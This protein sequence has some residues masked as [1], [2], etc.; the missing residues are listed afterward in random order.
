MARL[1]KGDE[2]AYLVTFASALSI[3]LITG[4]LVEH[5]WVDSAL[6]RNAFGWSFFFTSTWDAVQGQFG[7]LPFIYGTVVTSAM[8]LIISVP[9]GIGAAIFLAELAPR[10]VSNVLTFLIELLAA[11]PSVIFGLLGFSFYCQFSRTTSCRSF[12]SSPV[13]FRSFKAHST[14]LAISRHPA[15]CRS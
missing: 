15:F 8:A 10:K 4:L 13:F 12:K 14:A 6:S 2:I 9:I 7:A 11:V 3:V 5:L 1:M